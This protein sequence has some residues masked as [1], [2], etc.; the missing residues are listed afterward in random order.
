MP[1]LST[2]I[3][4]CWEL[5]RKISLSP[6][7]KNPSPP[8]PL[9][10]S[11]PPGCLGSTFIECTSRSISLILVLQHLS[12]CALLLLSAATTLVGLARSAAVTQEVRVT[13]PDDS[14]GCIS[15][16]TM[17]NF[18]EVKMP[19]LTIATEYLVMK[20]WP[21]KNQKPQDLW[22][23]WMETKWALVIWWRYCIA[24]NHV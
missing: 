14:T 19:S 21:A 24:N 3:T 12:I 1:I 13:M 17:G 10:Y 7:A 5:W 4:P 16:G 18:C 22:Y 2:K 20:G 15:G 11:Q 6:T 23:F 9:H 8:F